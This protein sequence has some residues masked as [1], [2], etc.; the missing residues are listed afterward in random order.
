MTPPVDLEPWPSLGPD[1]ARWIEDNLVYGPGDLRGKPIRL[2]AEKKALLRRLYEVYPQGH[3]QAGRRRFKRCALSVRK[4]WAKSEYAALI[5]AAELHPEA[6]VR[7]I[8]WDGHGNPIGSGV[9]DPYIPLVAY[10]EEQSD[11]LAYSALKV[12]L[13]ESEVAGDFDIGL[14]RIMRK[15]GDGKAV[16]L[17]ASPDARD[18]ARTTFMVCD[19]THRWNLPRLKQAHRTMLAN[20][21]KRR[22]ADAWGLE[23]TTSY[24]PGEGSVAEMTMD[25]ARA[26]ADGKTDDSRLFFFHRQAKDAPPDQGGYDLANPA[27]VRAAVIEASGP[28]VAAWSD[29]DSIVEQFNDPTADRQYLCR[30][31]LNWIT[32]GSD[33]AFDAVKWGGLA[34]PRSI[35]PGE[36]I[37]LG[38][39]GSR[40]HDSTAIVATHVQSGYQ[41]LVQAWERPNGP[42][43]EGWEVPRDEVSRTIADCFERWN[44]WR[45]YGD[46]P[47]WEETMATWAGRF[48]SDRVIEWFTYR[49]RPM[50]MALM[51][52]AGAMAAEE[53]SHDG[54]PILA[55]HIGNS[56]KRKLN[57]L[58][59]KGERLWAIVKERPD[60]PHKIDAAIAGCLAWEARNDAV[61]EGVGL[62]DRSVYED[63][64]LILI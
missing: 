17:A 7:T 4:G 27:D 59:D 25:Y 41:W 5:A 36:T 46:P 45:L 15:K 32:Q 28:I 24:A 1:V 53:L 26:V 10:T 3:P 14:M 19:E 8:G 40:N 48:G 57:I 34:Q 63:R 35:L 11:E 37:T 44:V 20:L 47:G 61:T 62:D 49:H 21:P 52:Y 54:S 43:G 51:S 55:A 60:S 58:D 38:F 6:P 23:I 9:T 18:G 31:W 50:A 64:G 16:S 29:I 2:D 13:E 30:V 42:S 33:R 22:L 12:I 56:C 39:D